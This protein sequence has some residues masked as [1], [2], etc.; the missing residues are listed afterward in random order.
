[1]PTSLYRNANASCILAV[2]LQV[3]FMASRTAYHSMII[4]AILA[5]GCTGSNDMLEPTP[6][7]KAD[8]SVSTL[9]SLYAAINDSSNSG[10]RVVVAPGVYTLDASRAHG[11][12]IELQ[13]DMSL[14]GKTGDRA[15]VVIDAANLSAAS[16]TDGTLVTGAVRLGRGDNRVEWL[17]VKNATKGSAGITTDLILDGPTTITIAHTFASNNSH[18][19]DIRNTGVAAAGRVL[20]VV[21]T[22]NEVADNVIGVGQG[23]RVANVQGASGAYIRVTMSDNYAH[24]NLAGFLAANQGTSSATVVVDSRNDRFNGNGNGALILG[25]F[26]TSTLVGDG[27]LVRLSVLSSNFEHNTGPLGT[28]FPAHYGIGVYGGVTSSAIGASDNRAE[29]ELH[30]AVISDNA[31]PDIAAWGAISSTAQPAGNRNV[32]S[33]TLWGTSTGA[34]TAVI[35]SA[36]VESSGTNQV[37]VVR[38]GAD[39]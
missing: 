6:D 17:T 3:G 26:A 34:S 13:K 28:T 27:N 38:V 32:A 22:D 24:G 12:R 36:P 14:I 25:G 39:R 11:G 35:N 10:R 37:I 21:L 31:G 29:L 19:I 33:V 15:A 30:S 18:G 1:M 9:D 23:I 20:D 2:Q 16:L 8:I 5:V 4:A 7:P